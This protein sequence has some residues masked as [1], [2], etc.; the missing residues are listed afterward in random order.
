[1]REPE[2]IL[3]DALE[4]PET[5]RARLAL[6]LA[7]SLEPTPDPTAPDAWAVEISRRIERLRDGTASTM[8]SDEAIARARA[9]LGRARAGWAEAA[10]RASAEFRRL[11][12]PSAPTHFDEQE[13]RW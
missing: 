6:K 9:R 12:D 4:L 13:R 11:P 3:H 2:A 5:D 10:Q 1:M 7:E 8:S